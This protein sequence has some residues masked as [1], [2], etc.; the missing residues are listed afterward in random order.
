M[1]QGF[2]KGDLQ[3]LHAT[4]KNTSIFAEKKIYGFKFAR[5]V[6]ATVIAVMDKTTRGNTTIT[7]AEKL[8]T[9]AAFAARVVGLTT[10]NSR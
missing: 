9:R 7:A 10:I 1:S 3:F 6:G 2:N 4:C 5:A 8:K